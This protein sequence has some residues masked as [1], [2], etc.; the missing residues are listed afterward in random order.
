MN[1]DALRFAI[2]SFG[3]TGRLTACE[4]I[5]T[6]HINETYRLTFLQPEGERRYLLQH[7]NTYV[8][9]KPDEVME[10]VLLVTKHIR[11]A[12]EADGVDP[13]ARVLHVVLTRSGEPLCWD[14]EG[15]AWRAYDNIEHAHSVDV[16]ES[17]EQFEG[18]GRAFGG[19]QS[20]LADFPIERLHETIPDFHDTIKRLAAFEQSVAADPV[21]R[22]AGVKAEIEAV[23][24]RGD[25]MGQIVRM[26]G[27][28]DIP[29]RVTHN[30]TKC[31]NVMVDDA[32]GQ[33]L[34]VIDLDTVMAGSALYD[35]GDAIRFGACTAAED[36]PDT[37]KVALDMAMFE[38]FTRG[39]VSET[40]G[41]LTRT[42]LEALPLGAM[43]MTYELAMRFLKDYIDGDPYFRTEYPEH[44]LVRARCQLEL[45][46]DMERK[47][48]E[49][50]ACVRGLIGGEG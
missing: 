33:P 4:E 5:T 22:A 27:A 48:G 50:D 18:V 37:S 3:F 8:F 28:G 9:K 2:D 41:R 14:G 1:D 29:L 47:R 19:F 16:V 36:E 13:T 43:V 39:F 42:E 20:M 30:D 23:R 45:L 49:M 12:L 21:G 17:P 40:A 7:I 24:A 26:I 34:C 31:N 15:R 25:A 6:G 10:N 32:T 35:Y 38:A 46:Y 11:R 44:N